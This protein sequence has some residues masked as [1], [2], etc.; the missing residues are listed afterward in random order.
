MAERK[1]LKLR[2]A[3]DNGQVVDA[4]AF[5]AK[6][7]FEFDPMLD[8]VRLVYELDR[9]AFNGNVNLQLRIIHLEQ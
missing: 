7:K 4:I 8:S 9:N 6:D 2:L 1:H 3:L 5:G